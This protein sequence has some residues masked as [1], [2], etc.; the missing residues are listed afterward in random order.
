[1][2]LYKEKTDFFAMRWNLALKKQ[3]FAIYHIF[4][5]QLWQFLCFQAWKRLE[6][7]KNV[8]FY[9]NWATKTLNTSKESWNY[10]KIDFT[11]EKV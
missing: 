11:K 2:T 1:M 10:V 3:V 8:N 4:Q 6:L 5:A 9:Q 7:T